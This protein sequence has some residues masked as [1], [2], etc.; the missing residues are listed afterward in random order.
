[1]PERSI[2]AVAKT[3]V[4]AIGPRVRIP[5]S[6]QSKNP[7]QMDIAGIRWKQ[8]YKRIH[9]ISIASAASQGILIAGPPLGIT[10]VIPLS[11]QSKNPDQMD[12]AGIRWKQA[13]KRI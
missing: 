4:R 9:A 3:V 11:P 8:A 6:P 10:P 12:I 2:G 5:L 13:Y 1:M 7:D